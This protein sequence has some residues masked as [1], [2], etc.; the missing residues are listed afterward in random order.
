MST[1][2]KATDRNRGIHGVAFNLDDMAERADV[3]L[4]GIREQARQILAQASKDA[5]AIRQQAEKEGRLA[6]ERAMGETLDGKVAEQMK[7]VLPALRAAIDGIIQAQPGWLAQW[8][9]G[10]IRL[11]ARMA[12]HRAPGAE[13]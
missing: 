7:T 6:A 2:I 5:Q 10:A 12:V 13:V 4:E 1:I 8:E 3:Y 11:A 9:N